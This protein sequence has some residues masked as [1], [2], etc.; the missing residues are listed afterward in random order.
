[1]PYAVSNNGKSWRSISADMQLM[2]GETYS[3][4]RPPDV[5][6]TP[7]EIQLALDIQTTQAAAITGFAA[8]PT[9]ARTYTNGTAETYILNQIWNGADITTVEAYIDAQIGTVTGANLAAALASVN[10]QLAGVRNVL[11]QAAGAIIAIRGLFILTSKL[12]VY[13]RDLV[14][15]WR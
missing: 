14:I 6:P 15:R 2:V 1:M 11:K 13:I 10:A 3:E 12:L 5:P 9:W 4:T 7:E 8:L